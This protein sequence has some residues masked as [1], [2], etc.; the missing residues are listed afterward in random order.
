[1][2]T[3]ASAFAHSYWTMIR[4]FSADKIRLMAVD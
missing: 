3:R 1:V 4:R 2:I